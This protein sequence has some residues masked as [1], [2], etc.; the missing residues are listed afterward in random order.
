MVTLIN[1]Q[2]FDGS[3]MVVPVPVTVV[4]EAVPVTR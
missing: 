3:D 4:P 2:L 1:Q